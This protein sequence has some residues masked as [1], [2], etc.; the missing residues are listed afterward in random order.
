MIGDWQMRDFGRVRDIANQKL[1][2]AHHPMSAPFF[3]FFYLESFR[4]I[5]KRT[6]ALG[7]DELR[8]FRYSCVSLFCTWGK[9]EQ[10]EHTGLNSTSLK[11]FGSAFLLTQKCNAEL[12]IRPRLVKHACGGF[13]IYIFFIFIFYKN[14]FSCSKFT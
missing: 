8:W 6:H 5:R 13:F 10:Q 4:Q 3:L 12:Q 9:S 1:C 14:I 2:A 11:V 7:P